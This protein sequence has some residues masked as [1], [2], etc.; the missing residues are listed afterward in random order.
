MLS[1]KARTQEIVRKGPGL[2][3]KIDVCI[4]IIKRQLDCTR[5]EFDERLI[6]MISRR[7]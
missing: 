7:I 3:F 5:H 4:E 6:G 2:V 1:E